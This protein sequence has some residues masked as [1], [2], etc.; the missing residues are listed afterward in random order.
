MFMDPT[1]SDC[2]KANS[3]AVIGAGPAGLTAAVSMA[4]A[5]ASVTCFGPGLS[6]GTNQGDT[7]TSALMETS[8]RLLRA[9]G[10]WDACLSQSA[11]LKAIR[12]IDDTGR[13]IRAPEVLFHASDLNLEA[14]GYN[15]PNSALVSALI[16]HA[17]T[18]SQLELVE[19]RAVTTV[20]PRSDHV[21]FAL[22]DGPTERARLVVG[23]DGRRSVCRDAAAIAIKDW[24]YRQSAIACNFEHSLPHE[25]ISNE[26]HRPA[27]PFTTVPLPGNA[28]SLV[29]V[30]RP[31]EAAR[32]M[33]LD[34]DGF[35]RALDERLQGV[36]GQVRSVSKR[37]VFP[38]SGLSVSRLADRRIALVGEAAHV[39]P[40]IGAQGLNLGFRDAAALADCVSKALAAGRDIG[41][42]DVMKAYS[43]ARIADISSRTFAVDMLNR[44][45][46]VGLIP[47]QA[48]R[49]LGLQI[50]AS[51]PTLR[52]IVMQAG[53]APENA[54]PNNLR[55]SV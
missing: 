3:V 25:S 24:S 20:V 29:W 35:E 4:N 34:A 5:G 14:F 55:T 44:S 42:S 8:I 32:L 6:S 54:M 48:L 45:V 10:V 51:F 1:P 12:L 13:L 11:P 40:P 27:G 53:L 26:F 49:S 39:I 31:D 43:K 2:L 22:E 21:E 47:V 16:D 36:L 41:G 37:A 50:L 19:T 23:A 7:R 46:L 15:V 33:A 17:T 28:S 9:N 38:L 52:K 18:M 30:E